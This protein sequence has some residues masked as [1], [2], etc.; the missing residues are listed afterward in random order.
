M[1]NGANVLQNLAATITKSLCFKKSFKK[2]K[3]AA[4]GVAC[5]SV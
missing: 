3:S 4:Q 5:K 2:S 1:G